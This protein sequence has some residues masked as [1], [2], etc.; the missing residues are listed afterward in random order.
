MAERLQIKQITIDFI[1][2]AEYYF[3][4]LTQEHISIHQRNEWPASSFAL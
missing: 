2:T 1:L 4:C 3:A